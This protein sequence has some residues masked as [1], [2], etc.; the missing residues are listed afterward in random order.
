MHLYVSDVMQALA[1]LEEHGHSATMLSFRS[2]N[3]A[4]PRNLHMQLI[5]VR[6]VPGISQIV[7]TLILAFLLP[8]YVA[9]SN[10]AYVMMNPDVSTL[11]SLPSI[12]VSKFKKTKFILDIRSTPVETVGSRGTLQRFWFAASVLVAKRFFDGMTTITPLMRKEICDDFNLSSERIGIW[13]SGV[14]T[15]LFN[16]EK[17]SEEA[18]ALRQ[19]LGLSD[20]FVVF[21]HGVFSAS[22]GLTETLGAIKILKQKCPNIALFLLGSGPLLDRLKSMVDELGLQH[23]VIIHNSVGHE[24][25]PAFICLSDVCILPL[26]F[27]PYWR[28]QCPLK[29]LEYLSMKK[30][31]IVT[32]LPANRMVIGDAKCGI[33]LSSVEPLEIAESIEYAYANKDKLENWGEFGRPIVEEKYTWEK[34]VASLEK[35]LLSVACDPVQ[36]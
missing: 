10:P 8:F 30:V 5:P 23:N 22:R 9:L 28:Y 29:L 13:T 35:Y 4:R 31:A 1:H 16:P 27:S 12:I 2:K 34:V 32:D 26:Q 6:Y 33:Y 3:F 20:K 18:I 15:S 17:H 24:Q 7:T 21:Y 14:S 36:S 11:S 19:A 25:V